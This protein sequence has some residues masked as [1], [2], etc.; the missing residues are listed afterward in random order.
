MNTIPLVLSKELALY[1]NATNYIYL[2]HN[3]LNREE[4]IWE[5]YTEPIS[6]VLISAGKAYSDSSQFG[7]VLVATIKTEKWISYFLDYIPNW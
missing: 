4:V 5:V 2:H 6:K 1:D 7:R 3:T